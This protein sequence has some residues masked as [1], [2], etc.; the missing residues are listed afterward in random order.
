MPGVT[1]I[2][3]NARD[4]AVNPSLNRIQASNRLTVNQVIPGA[5]IQIKPVCACGGGCPN[6]LGGEII[7]PK[8]KL[9]VPHDQYE[10]EADRVADQVMHMPVTAMPNGAGEKA[11]I[12]SGPRVD[13][14]TPIIQRQA[15]PEEEEETL[16]SEPTNEIDDLPNLELLES[17]P[18]RDAGEMGE[19]VEESASLELLPDSDVGDGVGSEESTSI[20]DSSVS[21]EEELGEEEELIQPKRKY[22]AASPIPTGLTHDVQ[23]LTGSGQPL[24]ASERA[25]FESRFARDFSQVRTHSDT[26]AASAAQSINA[27]AFTFGRDV[28]FGAGQYAP[29]SHSG[30]TLLAHELVHVIQQGYGGNHIIQRSLP[31][32]IAKDQYDRAKGKRL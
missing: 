23:A 12:Q 19:S 31:I 6:C 3:N 2:Q 29:G 10:Q 7:Q 15:F 5:F 17:V 25:F 9:G 14:I 11:F 22:A 27:R 32:G 4:K 28:V 21:I 26:R 20:P 18:T 30:R 16:L 24:P 8:L 13:S 1:A